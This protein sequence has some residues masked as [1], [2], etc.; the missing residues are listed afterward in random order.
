MINY[1]M[2]LNLSGEREVN[3][4]AMVRLL[5]TI[6]GLM[7]AD[8]SFSASVEDW[9]YGEFHAAQFSPESDVAIVA[10]DTTLGRDR[11]M[12]SEYKNDYFQLADNFQ[13][14]L[15]PLYCGIAS[16]VIVLNSMRLATNAVPSQKA[17]EVNVPEALGGG[18]LDYPSYSQL[19]LLGEK[20]DRVKSRTVIELRNQDDPEAKLD[21]G[22]SLHDLYGVLEVYGARTQLY[23]ADREPAEG[24]DDFRRILKKALSDSTHFVIVN[25]HGKTMGTASDGH[26]SPVAAYDEKSDSVLLLDVAGYLNPWYW[27]P[28]EHLYRAMH[29]RDGDKYRG[30][31]VISDLQ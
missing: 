19:T 6:L 29:T 22:L 13:P 21:P 5:V 28:T 24:T 31:V 16:S 20:T 9:T 25:F 27:V 15:N 8:T 23:Y 11:L 12:R 1:S 4:P 3:Y 10:W 7:L 17:I 2:W 30:Y 18:R 14:Q 26:I